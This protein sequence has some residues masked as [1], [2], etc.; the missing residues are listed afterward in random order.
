MQVEWS[1]VKLF[2]FCGFHKRC[3]DPYPCP[4]STSMDGP[5]GWRCQEE[6]I[7]KTAGGCRE[8]GYGTVF[9]ESRIDRFPGL[10]CQ[11]YF[12]SDFLEV[13]VLILVSFHSNSSK[14]AVR[15][16]LSYMVLIMLLFCFMIL[17]L[18]P[19]TKLV[20][21]KNFIFLDFL[22]LPYKLY[23]AWSLLRQVFH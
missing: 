9:P 2:L 18:R 6:E 3:T 4:F 1:W 23:V 14:T 10:S 22:T 15:E 16:S 12:H 20:T 8:K 19:R 13:I 5:K 7:L 21:H 17:F 11:S